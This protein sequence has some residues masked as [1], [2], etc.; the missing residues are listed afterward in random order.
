MIVLATGPAALSARHQPIQDQGGQKNEDL[1]RRLIRRATAQADEDLMDSMIRLMNEAGRKLEIDFDAGEET[2]AIQAAIAEK[3][4]DAIKVAARQRRPRRRT[5]SAENPD[6]RQ[7]PPD[8]KRD[9]GKDRSTEGVAAESATSD[10]PAPPG[11]EEQADPLHGDLRDIRR[12]WGHLPSRQ[13][14]EI[15][16]GIGEGYLDRYRL[17]IE[18]YYRA[19]QETDE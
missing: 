1:S 8:S 12:G 3:L 5:P 14:D 19:L 16:Q 9:E 2:R 10:G 7:M 13:R 6:R 17:W 15:I 4:D 18:Q 11:A